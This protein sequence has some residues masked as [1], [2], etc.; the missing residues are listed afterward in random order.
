[1]DVPEMSNHLQE[2]SMTLQEENAALKDKLD[3][4]QAALCPISLG[5]DMTTWRGIL[6]RLERNV[7]NENELIQ[8]LGRSNGRAVRIIWLRYRDAIAALNGKE[9]TDEPKAVP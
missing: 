4:I 3:R 9:E 5:T 7:F 2:S 1:M 8:R 6:E